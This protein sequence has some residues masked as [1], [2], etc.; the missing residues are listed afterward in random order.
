M[1]CSSEIIQILSL[2]DAVIM[3]TGYC[4]NLAMLGGMVERVAHKHVS[5]G[6]IEEQYPVVGRALIQALKDVLGN[7]IVTEEVESAIKEG[8]YYLAHVFI[9][10][11]EKMKVKNEE[12]VGGWRGWRKMI[13][14]KKVVETPVH[15]SFYFTPKDGGLLMRFLPGQYISLRVPGSPY[16]MVRNYSLSSFVTTTYRIT[17]KKEKDGQV[18]S[19]LHDELQEGAVLEVGVP[20][21]DFVLRPDTR[22]IVLIGAGVGITPLVSILQQATAVSMQVTMIYRAHEEAMYPLKE[23]VS[24]LEKK[25]DDVYV[26]IFY[27]VN[28]TGQDISHKYSA[29]SL[30]KIIPTKDSNF[31]LCG[32]QGFLEDTFHFLQSIG[33]RGDRIIQEQFGPAVS[34][35]GNV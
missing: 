6:V 29:P 17:V 26:N 33:V 23:E 35:S 7:D 8:Y 4:D 15:T 12:S 19:Y 31:Y 21:G 10:K 34:L 30:Q 11:E 18:S 32:P 5:C 2:V 20:C 14:T 3:F 22:P 28:S 1:T 27:T 25:S 9:D 13:L 24:S 16:T